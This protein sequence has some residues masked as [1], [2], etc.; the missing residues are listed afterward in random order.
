MHSKAA[1]DVQHQSAHLL[2][3]I[4]NMDKRDMPMAK[5]LQKK[6]MYVLGMCAYTWI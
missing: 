3:E 1:N 2:A 4:R 5:L 6:K